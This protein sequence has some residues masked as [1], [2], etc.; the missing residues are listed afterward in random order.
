M[1]YGNN[2]LIE[3]KYWCIERKEELARKHK[4]ASIGPKLERHREGRK[5]AASLKKER[6][7]CSASLKEQIGLAVLKHPEATK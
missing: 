6:Q 3:S 1:V 7:M 5:K 4:E 2:P